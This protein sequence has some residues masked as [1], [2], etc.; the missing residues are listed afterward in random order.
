MLTRFP[1]AAFVSHH[2]DR[3]AATTIFVE[4]PVLPHWINAGIYLFEAAGDGDAAD[5]GTRRSRRS[6]SG[7]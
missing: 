2:L 6:A 4:S 3:Q 7:S 1:I 5:R